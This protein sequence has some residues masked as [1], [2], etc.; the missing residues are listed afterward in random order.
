[1][2]QADGLTTNMVQQTAGVPADTWMPLRGLPNL[3]IDGLAQPVGTVPFG[4]CRRG[5]F[6]GCLDFT[7][8][9]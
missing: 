2:V 3:T 9:G 4:P 7:I 1:M 8:P 5:D 6:I